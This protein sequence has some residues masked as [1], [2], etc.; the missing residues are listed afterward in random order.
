MRLQVTL[1]LAGVVA[2]SEL[3]CS[4]SAPDNAPAS[5][6]KPQPQP[7]LGVAE[8]RTRRIEED[9]PEVDSRLRGITTMTEVRPSDYATYLQLKKDGRVAKE[10]TRDGFVFFAVEDMRHAPLPAAGGGAGSAYITVTNRF[11][12]PIPK[13]K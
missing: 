13:D 1:M 7:F 4:S 3:G 8:D 12:A 2:G 11:K 6:A 5:D 10:E 9:N